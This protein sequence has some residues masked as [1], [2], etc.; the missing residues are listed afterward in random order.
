[1]ISTTNPQYATATELRRFN[2]A[3]EDAIDAEVLPTGALYITP[4]VRD[5]E[6]DLAVIESEQDLPA[7]DTMP[8]P[9]H[10]IRGR[11][12][13][14]ASHFNVYLPPAH[15]W[16]GRFFQYTYPMDDENASA[17]K[18][19]FGADAG[20]Y[21]VQASGMSGY[22]HAAAAAR[23][24][25]LLAA[26]YYGSGNRPIHGYLY[27]PS[28]GSFQ[29]MGGVECTSGIWDGFVPTVMGTPVSLPNNFF[30][31]ALARL[32]L[33]DVG[34]QI[35]AAVLDGRDLAEGLSPLQM[36]VFEEVTALGVP[37]SAWS[38]PGYVLGDL[39]RDGLPNADSLTDFQAALKTMDP[40]YAEDFWTLHGYEGTEDTP[41]GELLRSRLVD[42]V[43]TVS[44]VVVN[45]EQAIALVVTGLPEVAGQADNVDLHLSMPGAEELVLTAH[46]LRPAES[47]MRGRI[48]DVAPDELALAVPADAPPEVLV[49]LAGRPDG[50][51]VR[52]E[53]RWDLAVRLYHR[54]QVPPPEEGFD[55]YD[56]FRERD[57]E[58]LR[59]QRSLRAAQLMAMGVTGGVTY[60][61]RFDGKVMLV[62]SQED[63]DAYTWHAD[64]Y[65]RR[66][67][68]AVGAQEAERCLRV[69]ITEHA[70]HHDG[71]V[72][73][74]K[75]DRLVNYDPVVEQALRDLAAWC[76]DGVEPPASTG[77]RV[78][79][80]QVILAPTVA[81][82]AGL[83]PLVRIAV[84][85]GVDRADD[86]VEASG[87]ICVT[88]GSRVRLR[89]DAGAP[90]G[91][92]RIVSA[93]WKRAGVGDFEVLDITPGRKATIEWEIDADEPGEHI[94]VVTVASVRGDGADLTRV[95]NLARLR[96][97]VV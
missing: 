50:W 88:H 67:V 57:G 26:E 54:H 5:P 21:T 33:V 78:A 19:C 27:G 94:V 65:R 52:V 41:L 17:R 80:G 40:D 38:E 93:A 34:E 22:R 29:T 69:Y 92:G 90:A 47:E 45:S 63:A 81:E 72:S 79:G 64:W 35:R 49:A 28:G 9:L 1:M 11:F 51:N 16:R 31:R 95:S 30:I 3:P 2:I 86:G 44:R 73:P 87:P 12:E 85:D 25:R 7:T 10:V 68:A 89:A 60:S 56:R 36:E 42:A 4:A 71:P 24:G 6:Y 14:T 23:A 59:P 8:V 83:Q 39:D 55:V 96:L 70:D 62:S 37:L 91:A 76:E 74:A 66:V 13:G 84:S 43:G 18:L 61:G 97:L 82:R 32:A 75:R 77:Y 15:I 46:P 48:G 58:S 20:G 53:N